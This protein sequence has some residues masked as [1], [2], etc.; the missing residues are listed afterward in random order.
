MAGQSQPS[1]RPA[2]GVKRTSAQKIAVV[3]ETSTLNEAERAE[4][5]RAHG[6]YPEE[7]QAWRE[8]A[9]SAVSGGMVPAK[10]F[11]A[12]CPETGSPRPSA[13]RCSRW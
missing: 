13:P 9:E 10:V 2:S 3:A 11:C 4:Y 6:V 12:R 8:S 7:V 5:C 1:G